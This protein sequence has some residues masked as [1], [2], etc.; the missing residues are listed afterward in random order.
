MVV[1]SIGIVKVEVEFCVEVVWIE[2][3]GFVL[4]VKLKVQVLVIEMEVEFQRVQKV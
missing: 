2:G 4:Q 1:E 3:E